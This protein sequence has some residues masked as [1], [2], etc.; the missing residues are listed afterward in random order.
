MGAVAACEAVQESVKTP[1]A[2][3]FAPLES[4]GALGAAGITLRASV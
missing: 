3:G 2:F 1:V 4:S